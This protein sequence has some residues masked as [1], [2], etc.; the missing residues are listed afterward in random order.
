MKKASLNIPLLADTPNDEFRSLKS[1]E[2]S[3]HDEEQGNIPGIIDSEKSADNGLYASTFNSKEKKKK[4]V[5]RVLTDNS[6]NGDGNPGLAAPLE[7]EAR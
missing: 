2:C 6:R 4:L 7:T 5:E 1:D 3:D